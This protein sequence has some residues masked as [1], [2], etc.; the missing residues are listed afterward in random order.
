MSRIDAGGLKLAKRSYQITEILDSISNGLA[1]L[2]SVFVDEMRIGQVLTNL[3][4][5]AVK[6]SAEGTQITIEAQP[7]DDQVNIIVTD[8]GIGIPI[9]SQS[10]L[11]DRFYQAESIVTGRKHG[12]GLGLSI[13]KGIIEAHGGRIWVASKM[14]EGAKF[15]FTLPVGKG[16]EEIAKDSGY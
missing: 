14:G 5:N 8:E 6:F 3:V 7:D 10:K 12:T 4:E 1:D 9:E 11:F 16:E 15:G 13:C 2:P